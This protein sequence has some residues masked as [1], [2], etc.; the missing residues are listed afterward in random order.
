MGATSPPSANTTGRPR[1]WIWKLVVP[2]VVAVVGAL[3]VGALT[4]IGDGLREL[5]FP[6]KVTV[7]GSA[8]VNGQPAAHAR[9]SLDGDP[10]GEAD[11]T[12]AFLFSGVRA[13][14]HQLRIEATGAYTRDLRFAVDRKTTKRELG[15]IELRPLVQLGF[16]VPWNLQEPSAFGQSPS[17]AYDLTLWIDAELDVLNRIQSVTYIRPLPLPAVAVRGRSPRNDFC[18]REAGT[19][20]ADQLVGAAF[21]TAS[22]VVTYTDGESS[23]VFALPASV[24]PPNCPVKQAGASGTTPPPMPSPSP[25]PQPSP[26]AETSPDV[27][28]DVTVPNVVCKTFGD[29][30][31]LLEREGLVVKVGES[32][33]PLPECPTSGRVVQQDP[34]GGSVVDPGSIVVLQLGQVEPT[35]SP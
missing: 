14:S 30:K 11:E 25:T 28:T 29:A 21:T 6:T 8:V 9:L 18:Y 23:E 13:G 26:P 3:L 35:P 20:P 22:A 33:T 10:A 1:G 32:L 5:L 17:V 16:V 15:L 7:T 31:N 4:P 19:L 12:G 24:P 34:V 27:T 2:I